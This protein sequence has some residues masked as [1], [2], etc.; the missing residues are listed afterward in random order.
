MKLRENFRSIDDTKIDFGY[1]L[2]GISEKMCL[3]YQNRIQGTSL[4]VLDNDLDKMH[5]YKNEKDNHFILIEAYDS[6]LFCS[7]P[8]WMRKDRSILVGRW[9]K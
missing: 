3:V 9:K 5:K 8:S 6:F 1:S 2:K 4:R 7:E